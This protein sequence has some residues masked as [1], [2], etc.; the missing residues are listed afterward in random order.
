ML[1][2]RIAAAVDLADVRWVRGRRDRRAD[3]GHVFA[4]ALE[5]RNRPPR[6]S[7]AV[8]VAHLCPVSVSRR[9]R[10]AVHW[11]D[12]EHRHLIMPLALWDATEQIEA[13]ARRFSLGSGR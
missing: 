6:R 7:A 3:P 12:D 2:S 9:V 1:V 4:W 8:H 5:R 11:L 10:P 13:A